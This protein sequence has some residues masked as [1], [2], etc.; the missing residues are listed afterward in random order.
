MTR[1]IGEQTESA[2]LAVSASYEKEITDEFVVPSVVAENGA[3]VGMI[4]E[5]DSIVFANFRP[6]RAREI[7]RTFVDPAF[8]GFNRE[9]TP[10]YF[11]CMTQY[12]KSMPNVHVAFKPQT[13]NNTFGEYISKNGLSQLRIAET[14][15]YAHVTFFFNGGVE[16][17]S[18]G[19]D[20]AL[21]NS[22]KVATYDLQPE[23]SAYEVTDEL[24]VRLDSGK[25]DVIIL[26]FANCDMVGHTGIIPAAIKAV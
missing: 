7:T 10:V 6:D 18:E 4:A 11:V 1:G 13:L 15:K 24:L 5:N 14:E 26:N 25:Y 9:Y 2:A 22:P 8:D 17:V 23:M 20:R 16:A 21:I 3:P 12:D 19:E